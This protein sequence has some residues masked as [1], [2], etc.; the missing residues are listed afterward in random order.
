MTDT[1]EAPRQPEPNPPGANPPGDVRPEATPAGGFDFNR[2]TIV[3]LLYLASCIL[4][5]TG[6]IGLVL[7]YVWKGDEH[8]PW[9]AT[10]YTY[11]IRTFWLGLAGMVLGLLLMIVLIGFP[12]M[13]ATGI[14]MLVR[15]IMSLVKAQQRAPMPDPQTFLI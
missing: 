2:P 13:L 6:I 10:H 15:I 4:G 5:V 14:W 11:L 3:S 9:E 8:Q 12:I 7:A 1:I